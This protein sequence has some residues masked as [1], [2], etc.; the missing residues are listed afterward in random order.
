MPTIGALCLLMSFGAPLRDHDISDPGFKGDLQQFDAN[1]VRGEYRRFSHVQAESFR[2]WSLPD[3]VES[4]ALQLQLVM[5]LPAV[6]LGERHKGW[7]C[8]FEAPTCGKEWSKVNG[9]KTRPGGCD[10]PLMYWATNL[11]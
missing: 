2:C 4:Q 8:Y 11:R 10:S 6:R 1:R 9:R 5:V 7:S 3:V